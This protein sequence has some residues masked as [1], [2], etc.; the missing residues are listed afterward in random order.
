ML[1]LLGSVP[2][3]APAREFVLVAQVGK[4]VGKNKVKEEQAKDLLLQ[5]GLWGGILLVMLVIA[6]MVVRRLRD[7]AKGDRQI[8]GDLLSNFQEMRREGDIDDAEFRNIKSV[9]GNQ[10]RGD[11]K[12]GKIK[13]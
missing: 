9:L 13:P 5:L 6:A 2:I 1:G 12:N 7:S 3:A 8:S 10:L 11:V 4:N